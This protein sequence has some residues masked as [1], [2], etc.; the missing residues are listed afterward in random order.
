MD[1]CVRMCQCIQIANKDA[2]IEEL[3]ARI[4]QRDASIRLN[5]AAVEE[6]RTAAQELAVKDA[7]LSAKDEQIAALTAR[8]AQF[9]HAAAVMADAMQSAPHASGMLGRKRSRSGMQRNIYHG[10]IMS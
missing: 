3:E 6:A 2:C 9:E 5:A 1:V 7:E 10:C 4:I 8:L